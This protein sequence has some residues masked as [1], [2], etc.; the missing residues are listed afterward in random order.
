MINTKS[1]EYECGHADG[2]SAGYQDGRICALSQIEG[3][4]AMIVALHD[5]LKKEY[6]HA[7]KNSQV[8]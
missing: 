2:Y 8:K 4:A 5:D 3:H 6:D 7:K 1:E